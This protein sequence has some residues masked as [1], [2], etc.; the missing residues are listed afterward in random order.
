MRYSLAFLILFILSTT[1]TNA[2]DW[3]WGLKAT[4]DHQNSDDTDI[5]VANDGNA[6]IAGYYKKSMILDGHSLY[7]T[8]DYYSDIFL[9]SLN[10]D[11]HVKWLISIEAGRTYS[12]DIGV[13]LDDDKNIYLTGSRNG[14]IFVS[15][16]DSTGV[17]I[18][19]T[20]FDKKY[21]GYGNDIAI[22]QFD[23]VYVIGGGG[24][25]F[26]MAKLNFYGE[27]VWAK[28]IQ[29]NSSDGFN[30][31]DIDVDALGNVYFAATFGVDSIKLDDIE[32]KQKGS[33]FWGK[34][35][36]NG[37]FIWAKAAKGT[38][39][40]TPQI[41][42]ASDNHIYI[43]GS[44]SER[45][46][47]E[48]T[49]LNGPCCS[50]PKPYIAKYDLQGNFIW[51]KT[52]NGEGN[53]K[54]VK[55]DLDGNLYLTGTNF[56][57]FGVFCTEYDYYIEKYGS[58][59]NLI[60]RKDFKNSSYD[61]AEGMDIDNNGF[62]YV[63]AYTLAENSIDEKSKTATNSLGI[64]KLNTLS[65]TT[66]RPARP[67]INR[68][69]FNCNVSELK[70]LR[71][72]GQNIKWYD[73]ATL[74]HQVH[75][76]EL[77]ERNFQNTDTLYV[78]QTIHNIESWPKE[79]IVYKVD[80]SNEKVSYKKDTLS[81]VPNKN[82]SYQ[83]MYNG[84]AIAGSNTNFYLPKLNG[85]YSV[86]IIAGNCSKTLDYIFER[87]NRPETDS[88]RYV[89]YKQPVGTLSAKGENVIWYADNTYR[90]TLLVG[91]QYS[92]KIT[93][94]KTLYVRQTLNGIASYPQKVMVKFS[95]LKDSIIKSGPSQLSTTYNKKFKY[96]WYYENTLIEN[97]D[98]N[99]YVPLKNGLYQVSIKDSIC[100]TLLSRY[101][102]LQPKISQ[103]VYTVC[104]NESMPTLT[105]EGSN[106]YWMIYRSEKQAYD[107]ISK[108]NSYI[109]EFNET[110]YI[111]LMQLDHGFSSYPIIIRILKANFSKLNFVST[112]Y[113]AG[114]EGKDNYNY[115]Y[116]WFFNEETSP[117]NS[118]PF[119]YYPYFGKYKIKVSLSSKCDTVFNCNYYPKFDSI[120]YICPN[121]SPQL[122]VASNNIRWFSDIKLTHLISYNSTIYPNLNGKDSTFYV[123]QFKDNLATWT[124]K[125]KAVYPG[126]EKLNIIQNDSALV[127]DNPKPY[128]K[129]NWQFENSDLE[130]KS[131]YC[132]P[133]KQGIYS[134]SIQA[135]NCMVKK[136]YSYIKTSINDLNISTIFRVYP[137]PTKDKLTIVSDG[138]TNENIQLKLYS[139]K[140]QVIQVTP[141]N[142]PEITIDIRSLKSGIYFLE[143]R[144]DSELSKFK[145]I[146]L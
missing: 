24:W 96:Q 19:N 84:N 22:D 125:V 38:T 93:A 57:C 40:D 69:F 122:T 138:L 107:T 121:S 65:T 52:T 85:K 41:A 11:G 76:G 111:Y 28:N 4:G 7:T 120:N 64:G 30:P 114:F 47:I 91:N 126:L 132:K 141:Y 13:A 5:A 88:L 129:Y 16:Y 37:K 144:T 83:W 18:W 3:V 48:N 6:V 92:P 145:I 17:L 139:S 68:L 80:L 104:S 60:W 82:F 66:K 146:K 46:S 2:Q 140:G 36:S 61:L 54:E 71:A 70:S 97:A 27:T 21:N 105:A 100:S 79:V 1:Q 75:T 128:F 10:P 108:T 43:S 14:F 133:D 32:I 50:G 25:N 112:D 99:L 67:I 49:V 117:S 124:G 15:K 59:G 34:L 131:F 113:S 95:E 51:A 20:D 103:T 116:Q 12:Y 35:D 90:D 33:T 42:L 143:L 94:N 110:N 45:L 63:A 142:N 102:V 86:K 106:L 137:N 89:C 135:G 130:F 23:N 115:T 136:S 55:L 77:L 72:I 74:S 31:N 81:V 8:D 109:P 39:T 73:T 118:S 134:V 101:F 123:A 62:L 53:T 9:G 78:T 44:F 98:S 29:V 87:P 119:M 127:V 58:S 56:D 26:F